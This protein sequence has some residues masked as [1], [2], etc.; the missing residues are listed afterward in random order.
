[1]ATRSKSR[2]TH[3]SAAG[4]TSAALVTA[5]HQIYL[6]GLGAASRTRSGAPG[7]FEELV[8]EGAR[9]QTETG[10][11]AARAF[12]AIVGDAQAKVSARVGQV[13]GQ[14]ADVIEGLERMFQTRVHRALTQLGVPSAEQLSALSKRVDALNTNIERLASRPAARR[15]PRR[16]PAGPPLSVP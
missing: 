15:A 7:L 5:L 14:A 10:A 9:A 11:A 13:R 4:G 1:M 3:L 2:K 6:A 12:Q 8:A 16:K